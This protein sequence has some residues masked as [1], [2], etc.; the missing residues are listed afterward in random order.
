MLN[1]SGIIVMQKEFLQSKEWQN[2]QESVGRKTF[3]IT[4]PQPSPSKG[5]GAIGFQANIIVYKLLLVGSYFYIPRGP[6]ISKEVND[7]MLKQVQHDIGE[8]IE[9]AKKEK[10]GWIR[11]EPKDNEELELI[12]SHL[13]PTLSSGRR[14][15]Y[16][17]VKAPHD[18]QPKETLILDIS[19]SEEE[20]LSQMKSKTRYNI[21]LSQKRGVSVK[22]ISNFKFPISNEISSI[23]DQNFK[24]Y[25]SEFLRLTN[26][27][28]KRQRIVTHSEKYYKKMFE[29][30]PGNIL[31]LYVAEYKGKV[32]AAN[33]VIFYGDTATYLHGASDD[34]YKNLMAPYLLQWRQ[35]Q[36]AKK[37][38]CTKYDF[39][40]IKVKNKNGKSWAGITRFKLGFAPNTQTI[41]FP[42]SYDIII[43]PIRYW[44]YR[45][46]QRLKSLIK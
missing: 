4:S 10:A 13:T 33:L 46:M 19:K 5:E 43:C 34:K 7:E 17:V 44:M 39:F 41:E 42:G 26:I 25:I 37:A 38:G 18:M 1:L 27:M 16:K 30:I 6:I 29:T 12:I 36:D 2:F 8:L 15:G 45:I 21:K 35:I 31:K 3:N 11:I 9:L 20:L 28:A 23:N 40:G 24:K 32:I 22:V 14:R